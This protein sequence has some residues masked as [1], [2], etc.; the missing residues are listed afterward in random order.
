[1]QLSGLLK[2]AGIA[3]E[4][5]PDVT[6]NSIVIDTRKVTPGALFVAIKGTKTDGHDFILDAIEKGAKVIVV[7]NGYSK[8]YSKDTV[9]FHVSDT[10]LVAGMLAAAFYGHPSNDFKLVGVTGTNGKT[11]V[12]TLLFNL[13][14]SLGYKAGLISTVE[15]KIN[16]RIIPAT[17]TT[18]DAISLQA[19]LRQMADEG[20]DYVFMEVSS[21]ALDQERVSAV[22]FTGAVFTNLTHDHLDYHKTFMNYL[23]AKKK[24]F[25]RLSKKSFALVNADDKN[26]MVMLQNCA[27]IKKTFSLNKSADFRGKV[28]ENTIEGLIMEINGTE[29]HLRLSGIFNAYNIIAVYGVAV[30]M[31]FDEL[32]ILRSLSLLTPPPGRLEPIHDAKRQVTWFVDYAH[33]DN[34]LENVINTLIKMNS[35]KGKII[36]VTGCGGERDKEKRPKMARVAAKLS[37]EVIFTSDNPRS[38]D[39]EQILAEM[40]A[41]V[42]TDLKYKVSSVTNRLQAIKMAAKIAQTGDLVLIAGKGH[43]KYQE[44][45]GVK[46]EFDDRKVVEDII[47]ASY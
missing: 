43:E 44:I 4:E 5:I 6:V 12:A 25:D 27:A 38:E 3:A 34:A 40:E 11:T 42:P 23:Q 7:Q 19:L 31:G 1:M 37:D 14:R 46:Y 47:G 41:G 17:H 22:N 2:S 26:G 9:F 8:D 45:K 15:N 18:P 24:F 36:T 30:L 39:P 20:C 13:V 35:A 33:T 29:I 28:I 10:A 16:D 21:H 32:E